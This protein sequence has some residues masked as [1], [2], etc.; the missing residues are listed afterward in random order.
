MHTSPPPPWPKNC[1]DEIDASLIIA[2]LDQT[3]PEVQ[4]EIQ[5]KVSTAENFRILKKILSST[6]LK[7][8]VKWKKAMLAVALFDD[9]LTAKSKEEAEEAAAKIDNPS[10]QM[11][12]KIEDIL[13]NFGLQGLADIDFSVELFT[14]WLEIT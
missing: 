2:E 12:D 11:A 4:A 7:M 1:D 5:N 10:T 14:V 3:D 6:T 8:N 13:G 9:V